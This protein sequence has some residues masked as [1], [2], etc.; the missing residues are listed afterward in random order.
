[1]DALSYEMN[2]SEA[3]ELLGI[4]RVKVLDELV[5]KAR[6][7]SKA[8]E[9]ETP[10]FPHWAVV[11]SREPVDTE[12]LLTR[13]VGR[14]RSH[15]VMSTDAARV[16]ALWATMTWVHEKAAVHSPILLVTSPEANSGKTT[17]LGVLSF[18]VCRALRTAG[19]TPAA[20]YR[21]V[22]KW[23][24]LTIMVDEADVAFVENPDLRR[25]VNSGWTRGD[26]VLVCDGEDNEPRLFDTFCP[27]AIGMKG[28]KLPDTTLSR[29]II[30]EM[31]R[32]KRG[33]RALDFEYVD[34]DGLANIR[35]DLARFAADNLE[36][37]QRA[38]PTPPQGFE[39]RDAAHWRLMLSIADA[40][41]EE[42]GRTAREAAKRIAGATTTESVGTDLLA[43]IKAVFVSEGKAEI[44]S[45][46]LIELLTADP[47]SPWC[48]WG[49]DRKPITPNRLASMLREFRIKSA[50]VHG[51]DGQPDA[52]GYRQ[53]D[54][55]EAWGRYLPP[56]THTHDAFPLSETSGRPDAD[57][58]GTSCDSR[59]VREAPSG[60]FE[61]SNL[62]YSHAGSD[63]WTFQNGGNGNVC[64][65]DDG[66]GPSSR[67]ISTSPEDRHP[68]EE[69]TPPP[70]PPKAPAPDPWA[71]LEIPPFLD[72]RT[73]GDGRAPALGPPG[74]SL[75]DFK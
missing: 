16:V 21:A 70:P 18:L 7:Q 36:A 38:R 69:R 2:R 45:R 28:R 8:A 9:P 53:G 15:V 30:I 50:T 34:D 31:A 61:N 33:E 59:N 44:L 60:R 39:N 75:E 67:Q 3:A 71:G 65:S 42:W 54:F 52:K 43:D 17:L 57:G 66:F 32:R 56:E 35:S 63:V 23:K 49:Q 20:L 40:G 25:V 29:T 11:P 74:D 19:V 6:S 27:K 62:S 24:P 12:Q 68:T 72:R 46:R 13:L 37:L 10:L 58:M 51:R 1:M 22:D 47:E 4:R 14:I 48:E 41:G 5:Q 73:N 55:L 26:G 64:V